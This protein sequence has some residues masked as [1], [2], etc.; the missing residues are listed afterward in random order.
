MTAKV[1]VF[2]YQKPSI[3]ELHLKEQFSNKVRALGGI[4]LGCIE[5]GG[6]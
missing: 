3:T 2:S 5:L 4:D 6:L 1:S